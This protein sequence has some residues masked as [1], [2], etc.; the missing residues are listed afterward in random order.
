MAKGYLYEI[1]SF[2]NELGKTDESDFYDQCGVVAD[3]FE[4]VDPVKPTKELLC[5]FHQAGIENGT[6][7]DSEGN[8]RQWFKLTSSSRQE[9]FRPLYEEFKRA[10]H[11]MPLEK[12]STGIYTIENLL[13]TQYGD[14]I[15][16]SDHTGVYYDSIEDFLRNAEMDIK[17]YVGNVIY[18][19]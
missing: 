9:Y 13:E 11:D 18:M 7:E 19:H 6:E 15:Y 12:F 16:I 3:W 4:T 17:Y 14:A 8:T 5:R 1:S 10:A 2:I